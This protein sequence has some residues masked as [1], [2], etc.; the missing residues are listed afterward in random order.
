[1]AFTKDTAAQNKLPTV[2][3]ELTFDMTPSDFAYVLRDLRF[4]GGFRTIKLDR[5]ARDYL[6]DALLARI[7][8]RSR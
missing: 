7:G 6:L 3:N 1:M 2:P 8:D 5:D 4:Q